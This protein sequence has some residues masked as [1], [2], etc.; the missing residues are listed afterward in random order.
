[1]N[2]HKALLDRLK[3]VTQDRYEPKN[4]ERGFRLELRGLKLVVEVAAPPGKPDE[5]GM[6]K[7]FI[8]PLPC[9]DACGRSCSCCY[10]LFGDPAGERSADE[11]PL[12]L[13][14]PHKSKLAAHDTEGQL[15]SLLSELH[16]STNGNGNGNGEASS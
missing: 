3:K 11:Q 10:S 14:V 1:M 9:S 16:A 2:Q 6:V 8:H 7:L 4:L 15:A 12:A 5:N 13:L